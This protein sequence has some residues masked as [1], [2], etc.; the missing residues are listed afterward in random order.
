MF[1]EETRLNMINPN[2]KERELTRTV[3]KYIIITKYNILWEYL[4]QLMIIKYV[5]TGSIEN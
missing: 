4:Y 5:S 3:I 2:T 1:L